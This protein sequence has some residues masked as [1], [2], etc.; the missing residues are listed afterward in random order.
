MFRILYLFIISSRFRTFW[1]KIIW[2]SEARRETTPTILCLRCRLFAE[3]RR[4]NKFNVTI[5]FDVNHEISFKVDTC[6]MSENRHGQYIYH[7][8]HISIFVTT[9]GY[10]TKSS[11]TF[12]LYNINTEFVR[13]VLFRFREYSVCVLNI[14][15]DFVKI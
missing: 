12:I 8:L 7:V 9:F 13:V 10:E 15:R 14:Y 11:Y 3:P 6:R 4:E 2:Q 1:N 5:S